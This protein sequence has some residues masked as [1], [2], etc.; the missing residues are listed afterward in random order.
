MPIE[1]QQLKL[2]SDTFSL[3][4]DS[5]DQF[6]MVRVINKA[7]NGMQLSIPGV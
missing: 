4:N 2:W 7:S 1:L 3:E 5:S 6:G